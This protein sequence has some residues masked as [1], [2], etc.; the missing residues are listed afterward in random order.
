M[1]NMQEKAEKIRLIIS[2]NVLS[3]SSMCSQF[4]SQFFKKVFRVWDLEIK[5]DRNDPWMAYST[6]EVA[7]LEVRIIMKKIFESPLDLNFFKQTSRS[8]LVA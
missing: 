6:I 1:L 7:F 4:W 8:V 2:T 5:N 3:M